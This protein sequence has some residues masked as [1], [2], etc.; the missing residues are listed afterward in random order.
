M[1]NPYFHHLDHRQHWS[2][3]STLCFCAPRIRCRWQ[4]SKLHQL[5]LWHW[6]DGL[7]AHNLETKGQWW[8]EEW[9]KLPRIARRV[10]LERDEKAWEVRSGA[11]NIDATILR[12]VLVMLLPWRCSSCFS[13]MP[14]S[15]IIVSSLSAFTSSSVSSSG[16]LPERMPPHSMIQLIVPRSRGR[17]I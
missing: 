11:G 17:A 14:S 1:S 12:Q 3:A 5:F 9:E 15:F 8:K 4:H 2:R 13:S 16:F 7:S 6:Q 10:S